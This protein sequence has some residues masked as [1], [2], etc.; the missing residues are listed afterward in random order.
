MRIHLFNSTLAILLAASVW[1]NLAKVSTCA[2]SC[3]VS[4]TEVK[5]SLPTSSTP[6]EFGDFRANCRLFHSGIDEINASR[7]G[8]LLFTMRVSEVT[9]VTGCGSDVTSARES[10]RES[11]NLEKTYESNDILSPRVTCGTYTCTP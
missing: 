7:P 8:E 9:E 6:Q 10:A 1:P 5:D 4:Y 11:C 2:L 3:A